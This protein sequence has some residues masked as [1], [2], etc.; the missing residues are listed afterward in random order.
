ML[1]YIIAFL[2]ISS[3]LNYG[4]V[5]DL[6][7]IA[8]DLTIPEINLLAISNNEPLLFYLEP[9]ENAGE[10]INALTSSNNNFW[11]NYTATLSETSTFKNLT[12]QIVSG[13][14]PT[15]TKL[16]LEA[17]S[18]S[19]IGKGNLGSSE[20]AIELKNLPQ[21]ILS[22]IGGSFTGTG[23]N[24]GHQLLYTLNIT[25]YSLLDYED[26]TTLTVIYTLSDN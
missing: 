17:S 23:S 10:K 12:A 14:V 4:Q 6:Q 18:Y 1:K 5:N 9:I 15:G 21:V 2:F 24:N 26:T 16:M 20:G 3:T 25:N 13:K 22:N 11:I 8:V 19:G 7:N